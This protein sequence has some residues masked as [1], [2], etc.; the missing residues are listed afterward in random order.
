MYYIKEFVHQFGKKNY[1]TI[2]VILPSFSHV[3]LLSLEV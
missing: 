1:V 2:P 3:H